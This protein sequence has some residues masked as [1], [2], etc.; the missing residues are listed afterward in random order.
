AFAA[1]QLVG[2]LVL[3]VLR[4]DDRTFRILFRAAFGF[5]ILAGFLSGLVSSTGVGR[6]TVVIALA[7]RGLA[8][9]VALRILAG[10]EVVGAGALGERIHVEAFG[11][12]QGIA[13]CLVQVDFSTHFSRS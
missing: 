8:I 4:L 7:V 3:A 5:I 2:D 6:T 12:A 1:Q 11:Q 9:T 13:Q 10:D